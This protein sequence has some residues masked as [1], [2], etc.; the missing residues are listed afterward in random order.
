MKTIRVLGKERLFL[1]IESI[2]LL[3]AK[4]NYTII[5]I[6]N[7]SY[8]LSS[9]NLGLF[10]KRIPHFIRVNKSF[11]INQNFVKAI[12]NEVLHLSNGFSI[13]PSRRRKTNVFKNL[14]L[15]SN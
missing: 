8:F 15:F 4:V 5:Y 11:I 2:I 9:R 7:G 14:N 13:E 3:E 6:D 12:E 1:P 10:E